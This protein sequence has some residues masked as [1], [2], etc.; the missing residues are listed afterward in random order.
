MQRR[1]TP[2]RQRLISLLRILKQ[3]KRISFFFVF[4]SVFCTFASR[5]LCDTGLVLSS[6]PQ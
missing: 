6:L 3:N 4:Q 2:S 5:T 1:L